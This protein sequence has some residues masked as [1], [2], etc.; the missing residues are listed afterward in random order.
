MSIKIMG[1]DYDDIA[2]L[3][4]ADLI[5]AGTAVAGEVKTGET[6]YA[7][8]TVLITGNGT[9]TLNPANENVPAG[10]Y[11]AT[12]LSA[13]DGD[14]A[15]GN[16]ADGVT[17][18]GFLGTFAGGPLSEDIID[19][20]LGANAGFDLHTTGGVHD[21][22]VGGESNDTIN[23]LTQVYDP[24][25]MAVAVGF[26]RGNAEEANSLKAQLIMDGV[27]VAEGSFFGII[28][29]NIS[30]TILIGTRALSGSKTVVLQ[31]H[32]YDVSAVNRYFYA[33][34]IGSQLDDCGLGVGSVKI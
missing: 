19:I 10:Y 21:D 22:F 30:V 18:F 29:T 6:F 15:P 33:G 9:Q 2:K 23:S 17:I 32:N 28:G 14:L 13:V 11:A 7:G 26:V 16:I 20:D 3:M 12:T 24:N 8:S 1:A 27:Q 5:V 34:K 25:S 4:G 31:M